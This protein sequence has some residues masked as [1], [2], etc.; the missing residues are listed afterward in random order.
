MS[1][2]WAKEERDSDNDAEHFHGASQGV[3]AAFFGGSVA[4]DGS[5]DGDLRR[6][7]DGFGWVVV[8]SK[9]FA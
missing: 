3:A 2:A 5:L 1:K 7:M 9:E 8:E 6:G 4:L